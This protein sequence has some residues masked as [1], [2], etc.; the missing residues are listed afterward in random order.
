MNHYKIG[1]YNLHIFNCKK[2]FSRQCWILQKV[3]HTQKKSKIIFHT[4]ST[5]ELRHCE[6]AIS[7]QI[8]SILD[9]VMK[10]TALDD[11]LREVFISL[12]II[13]FFDRDI[14]VV[15]SVTVT[16][17]QHRQVFTIYKYILKSVMVF[18]M[19][20]MKSIIY[21]SVFIIFKVQ[22]KDDSLSL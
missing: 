10:V 11:V 15:V 9:E 2:L 8:I 12:L 17:H 21:W 16:E 1:E 4:K 18:P 7:L 20:T 3:R 13:Q 6:L 22:K 14:I 5:N 19:L